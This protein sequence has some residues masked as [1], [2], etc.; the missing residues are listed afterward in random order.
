MIDGK[1]FTDIIGEV[2]DGQLLRDLTDASYR[3]AAAVM[4]T[5]K[6]GSITITLKYAPTGRESV[7]IDAKVDEKIPKHT[8]ASTT[9]FVGSDGELMRNDPNQPKLPLR[10]VNDE[11][12]PLRRVD[13]RMP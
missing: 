2:E 1:P 9:F 13:E 7:Q 3:M 11:R 10:S 5:R 12:G 8:R 4:E 6:E